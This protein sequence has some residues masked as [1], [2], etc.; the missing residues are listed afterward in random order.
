MRV[1]PQLDYTGGY[2][3]CLVFVGPRRTYQ[4]I[5]PAGYRTFAETQGKV[6]TFKGWRFVIW[7][8]D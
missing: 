8:R 6:L 4:L 7:R 3:K 5:A 2:A 1:W